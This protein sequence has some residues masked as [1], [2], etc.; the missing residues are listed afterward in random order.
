MNQVWIT[1]RLP[2]AADA[3]QDGEV[4]IV[5][6]PGRN[7][8]D[9]WAFV[10]WS[11]VGQRAPWKHTGDWQPPT[12]LA[13]SESERI[14]ALE[15]RVAEEVRAQSVL[16]TAL[17]KRLEALEGMAPNGVA[18]DKVPG[19]IA[20]LEQRVAELEAFKRILMQSSPIRKSLGF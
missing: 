7:G 2:T 13:S 19:G 8:D 1:D 4:C 17:V 16:T 9:D 6:G 14:A 20:A 18:P 12:Q 15:Q 11:Y 5:T 10:H 3:D